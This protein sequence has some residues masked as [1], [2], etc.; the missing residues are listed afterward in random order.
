MDPDSNVNFPSV[1]DKMNK[2]FEESL[3][4][5]LTENSDLSLNVKSE[6]S[7]KEIII[8]EPVSVFILS[9]IKI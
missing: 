3:S 8:D 2:G 1:I 6:L 5:S 7:I 9:F 4:N